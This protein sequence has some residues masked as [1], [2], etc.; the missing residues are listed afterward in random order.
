LEGAD[1]FRK[2]APTQKRGGTRAAESG[3]P[4]GGTG[5][6]DLVTNGLMDSCM[7]VHCTGAARGGQPT[8]LAHVRV[9]A[10]AGLGRLGP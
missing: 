8:P 5:A 4:G 6:L 7:H 10:F 1:T 9:G 2:G 3:L